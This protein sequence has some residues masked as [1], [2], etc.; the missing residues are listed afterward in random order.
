MRWD[1]TWHTSVTSQVSPV[2][3]SLASETPGDPGLGSVL[4]SAA[5]EK[6]TAG[7]LALWVLFFVVLIYKTRGWTRP[8]DSKLLSAAA[9][10]FPT[11]PA[12][13]APRPRPTAHGG[14]ELPGLPATPRWAA[15]ALPPSQG[16]PQEDSL[17]APS[18]P[19]VLESPAPEGGGLTALLPGEE[20]F[21][22]RSQ[23]PRRG[24]C[25]LFPGNRGAG[26]ARCSQTFVSGGT[27]APLGSR[28]ICSPLTAATRLP[29]PGAEPGKPRG[30]QPSEGQRATVRGGT[31]S[32]SGMPDTD[33]A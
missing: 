4:L 12:P 15:A 13:A 8:T 14:W 21:R 3:S 1:V 19:R 29:G 20:A 5:S 31:H 24:T 27:P 25:Y 17:E 26:K 11:S 30:A 16:T 6:S 7:R 23:R 33:K 10:D 28:R 32:G 2:E 9:R 22:A 18:P